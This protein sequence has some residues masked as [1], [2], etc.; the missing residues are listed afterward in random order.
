M[1]AKL[2]WEGRAMTWNRCIYLLVL[3]SEI[4]KIIIK[5]MKQYKVMYNLLTYGAVFLERSKLKAPN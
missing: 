4:N 1:A 3:Q 2:S 5:S